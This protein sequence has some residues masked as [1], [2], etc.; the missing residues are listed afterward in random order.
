MLA[1]SFTASP[2]SCR[3]VVYAAGLLV[4]ASG[5]AAAQNVFF[6]N[7]GYTSGYV[8]RVY[9]CDLDGAGLTNIMPG[10]GIPVGVDVDA[11]T[12]RVYWTDQYAPSVGGNGELRSA[13]LNGSS[14]STF[15]S[16][17]QMGYG[18]ALDTVNQRV[19]WNQGSTIQRA[20]YNG[21]NQIT[22]ASNVLSETLEVDPVNGK[23][24]WGDRG[25]GGAANLSMANLDGT[26]PQ[27]LHSF[28][29]N[30]Y[31]G[32]ITVNPVTQ[33]VIWSDYY[34]GTVSSTPYGGGLITPIFTNLPGPAG[35]DLELTTNRLYILDRNAAS[36]QWCLPTG[37]PLTTV[38]QGAGATIGEM[39]DISVI[40]PAPGSG[41][42]LAS[43]MLLAARRRHRA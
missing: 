11:A 35:L 10:T 38:F 12:G 34:F 9:T 16:S 24:F 23:I 37:G 8:G 3:A 5:H 7:I 25:N 26:S 21:A 20:D 4:L 28:A 14:M 29:L 15:K 19:Y 27:I 22:V 18:V 31:P 6:G 36:V 42:L 41:A 40:V 32:G 33:T 39:W 43:A 1:S 13:N 30:S 2:R 17:Q